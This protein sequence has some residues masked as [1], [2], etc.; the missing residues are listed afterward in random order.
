MMEFVLVILALLAF[1]GVIAYVIARASGNPELERMRAL[2]MANVDGMSGIEFEN[3]VAALLVNE[4][5]TSVSVTPPSGDNG[6]D[7]IAERGGKRYSVQVKR[8]TGT[9]SR[10]AVSDAVAG[11]LPYGCNACMVIT[12]GRLSPKALDFARVHQ[13]EV[14]GREALSEWVFRFQKSS[15]SYP[16]SMSDHLIDPI[17]QSASK[18]L[19]PAQTLF[20]AGEDQPQRDKFEVVPP[21]VVRE[22]KRYA[23]KEYPGDYSTMEYVIKENLNDYHALQRL[24]AP[25]MSE[26]VYRQVLRNAKEQYP[27][28]YSTQLFVIKDQIESHKAILDLPAGLIPAEDMANILSLAARDYPI[29][30]ST[31]LFVIN[32]NLR[33]FQQIQRMG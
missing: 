22:I 18:V 28:N 5:F 15:P 16:S 14:I 25:A 20:D 21:D 26:E 9:V 6:V 33:A 29:D 32:D 12:S 13:C 3:Y 23:A 1:V 2:S 17:D 8:Y 19:M 7:I 10:R 11:M 24:T 27:A 30:F 4:G 31:Q